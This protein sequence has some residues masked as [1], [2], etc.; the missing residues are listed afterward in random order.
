MKKFNESPEAFFSKQNDDGVFLFAIN[1]SDV[2]N[3]KG[4]IVVDGSFIVLRS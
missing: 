4:Q 3:D 1:C 2:I